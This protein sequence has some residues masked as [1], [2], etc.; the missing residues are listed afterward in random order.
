MRIATLLQDISTLPTNADRTISRL[1]LDSRLIQA[2]DLFLA[3]QGAQADG[4]QYIANAIAS[5]AVA[6]LSEEEGEVR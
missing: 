6:V 3:V 4:R 2:G 1:I 5:G